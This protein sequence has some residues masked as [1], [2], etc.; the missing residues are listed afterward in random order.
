MKV[1]KTSIAFTFA[2]ISAAPFTAQAAG[3]SPIAPADILSCASAELPFA[4]QSGYGVQVI[5]QSTP[6]SNVPESG[7]H[8]TALPNGETLRF[9]KLADPVDATRKVLAFQVHTSDPVTNSGKRSELKINPNIEMNKVYWI[10]FS[11]YIYDWG[12]LSTGDEALFGTQMHTGAD[13]VAVGGPSF[14]IV[15][16]PGGRKFFVKTRYSES[17]TPGEGK[18]VSIKHAQHDIPFGRWADFV[19]KFKHNTSGAGFLQAWMDGKPIANYR[20]S[21]GYNTG[22]ADY[23]KFGYYNWSRDRMGPTV[24][25]VLLRSP[26]IVA[27]PT[28]SKYSQEQV[29]TLLGADAA[30][31]ASMR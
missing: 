25:K 28:G 14:G 16:A 9:G 1:K 30:L 10:A 3:S 24:R 2:L 31:T 6:V 18:S 21:L 17:S 15:T 4:Q 22:V 8:G 23:A 11:V 5:R 29:R 20:G 27:D 13:K 19:I 26:T 7:I 12:T